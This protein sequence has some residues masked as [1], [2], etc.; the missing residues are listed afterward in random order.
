MKGTALSTALDELG[1]DADNFRM[2]GLLPLVYVAWADGKVQHAERSLIHRLAKMNG[3]LG[4]DGDCLLTEWLDEPPSETYV[5]NGLEVLRS[6]GAREP[7][8]EDSMAA[9]ISYC[10]DVAIAAGG[11]FGQRDPVTD[12][13]TEA[14]SQIA[15]ALGVH[16]TETWRNIAGDPPEEASGPPGPRG[17]ILVGNLLDFDASPLAFLLDAANN[18]GDVVHFTVQ[19]DEVYLLR[20]PEHVERVLGDDKTFRR[21]AEY[22]ALEAVLGPSSV[23]T[24]GDDWKRLRGAMKPAFADERIH[25]FAKICVA[26]VDRMIAR[27]QPLEEIDGMVEMSRLVLELMGQFILGE[28]LGDPEAELGTHIRAILEHA[29][30]AMANPFRVHEASP[31]RRRRF[32]EAKDAFDEEFIELIL[33]KRKAPGTDL[34]SAL[35]SSDEELTSAEL[36]SEILSAFLAGHEATTVSLCWVFY[37][38]SMHAVAARRVYREVHDKL[39][40]RTPTHRDVRVLTY[41]TMFI[42]EVLRLYPPIWGID[43][44]TRKDVAFDDFSVPKGSVIMLSPWV[45]HRSPAVWTNPEGFDPERFTER[46]VDKR[47]AG[48][49]FPFGTGPHACVGG[50][51]ARFILRL[52]VARVTQRHRLDLVPGF[53]PGLDPQLTLLPDNGM[54]MTLRTV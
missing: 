25:G 40:A 20:K 10:R 22:R 24:M 12:S 50:H 5:A 9:L 42:D 6:L 3:W 39:R 43:R 17:H 35:V 14:L 34:L 48:A 4:D 47:H 11:L 16:G 28:D 44:E 32:R 37:A 7:A 54:R 31:A 38:L 52:V 23:T 21:G 19:R 45:T 1:V 18:Y 13:E 8:D 53:E 41:T 26:A 33:A 27:W 51:L 29:G 36:E 49:Y 2:L 15:E 46:A 30:H